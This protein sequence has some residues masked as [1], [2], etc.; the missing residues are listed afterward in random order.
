MLG[1]SC[2]KYKNSCSEIGHIEMARLND[3]LNTLDLV[4]DPVSGF[5][6]VWVSWWAL[7]DLNRQADE[8]ILVV[9]GGGT[10]GI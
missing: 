8:G 3:R 1:P 9:I 7:S 6:F 10:D 2:T 5:I 4:F